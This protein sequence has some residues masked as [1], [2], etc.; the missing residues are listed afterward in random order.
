MTL[1]NIDALFQG[2]AVTILGRPSTPAQHQLLANLEASVAPEHREHVTTRP[3]L[4]NLPDDAIDLTVVMQAAWGTARIVTRLGECGCRAL[5]WAADDPIQA[6]TRQAAQA[7]NLRMLGARTAGVIDT[8][9]HLNVSSLASIPRSGRVALI[10]QSQSLAAGALDWALGRNI[11]FSWLACTGQEADI[12]AADL[13]DYAALDPRTRA[14]VLQIGRI[15]S[16]RKFMSAARAAARIKPVLVLQTQRAVPGGRL[17]P[18]LA[19]SAA[20]ARAGLVECENM[21]GLFDGLA[22]LE[23]LPAPGGGR[24]AVLGN[25][26]GVC[27]LG[28]DAVARENLSLARLSNATR[29]TLRSAAPRL[30]DTRTAIDLGDSDIQATIAALRAADSDKNVDIVLFVHSPVA[31]QPHEPMAEALANANFGTRLLTVWVGL[32]TARTARHLI[33]DARMATFGAVDDAVRAVRYRRQHTLNRQLLTATP[34]P[35][36]SVTADVDELRERLARLSDTG[37][38]WLSSDE[39]A[40]LLAAYGIEGD[41]AETAAINLHIRCT[42]HAELGMV[43]SIQDETTHGAPAYGFAPL[44]ALLAERLLERVGVSYRPAARSTL[45]TLARALVRI[46]K[47]IVDLPQVALLELVLAADSRGRLLTPAGVLIEL[48]AT[49]L[50]ERRRLAMAPYPAR[51]RHRVTLRRDTGYIVRAIQ[52]SDEPAVL[53]LLESLGPEEIRLRFFGYIKHFSHD[54][55]ARM[56]QVDYDREVSL[57]ASRRETPDQI[58]GMATLIADPDGHEAEFALIVHHDHTCLGLGRHLLDCLLRQAGARG[59]ETVYGD[60]LAQNERMLRLARSLGFRI[61][62]SQED[63]SSVQAHIDMTQRRT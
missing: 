10:T 59:I 29:K 46:G 19:R 28:T 4:K 36:P 35:D 38:G 24:V 61:R 23:L 22:A 6:R 18:D 41:T 62:L 13:L 3:G 27:A 53:T 17:G 21:G 60:V 5:M 48:S 44:D 14:I 56:T 54:M 34:P 58:A 1:R 8:R 50:P 31:G 42:P 30:H 47:M 2:R 33:A 37:V 63:A 25:G 12:D 16:P 15:G 7:F 43:L 57:I 26:A 45:D 39:S 9:S 11:G 51:M 20:F 55:A 32:Q 40:L 49:T 52:P